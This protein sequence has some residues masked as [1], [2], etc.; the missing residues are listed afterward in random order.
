[1]EERGEPKTE[2]REIN[3]TICH[4]QGC[5]RACCYWHSSQSEVQHRQS[6]LFCVRDSFCECGLHCFSRAAASLPAHA[7]ELGLV[8]GA[9]SAG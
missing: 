4:V 1:M 8:S 2:V 9:L 3:I 7:V 6:V 5:G